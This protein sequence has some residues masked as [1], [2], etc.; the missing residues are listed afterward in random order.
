MT[1]N[2]KG[3]GKSRSFDSLRSLKMT[4]CWGVLGRG[5]KQIL[6]AAQDDKQR[7]RQGQKQIPS[8]NDNQKSKSKGKGKCPTGSF[9]WL[10]MTSCAGCGRESAHGLGRGF[11]AYMLVNRAGLGVEWGDGLRILVRL[12][13]RWLGLR[14]G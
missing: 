5:Q 7:Q 3:E 11:A 13:L 14:A 8:G 12:G 10:R 6:R 4:G 9:A 1:S 2:G